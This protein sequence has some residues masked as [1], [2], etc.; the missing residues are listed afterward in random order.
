MRST[1]IY[2]VSDSVKPIYLALKGDPRP[3]VREGLQTLQDGF[4]LFEDGYGLHGQKVRLTLQYGGQP[5][6]V[7]GRQLL[8]ERLLPSAPYYNYSFGKVTLG[9]AAGVWCLVIKIS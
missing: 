3:T 8:K 2:K 7:P 9:T 5:V 6:R 1:E 4:G